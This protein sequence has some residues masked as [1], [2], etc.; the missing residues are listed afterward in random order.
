MIITNSILDEGSSTDESEIIVLRPSD[1]DDDDDSE[2]ED[3]GVLSMDGSAGEHSGELILDG[4]EDD[5]DDDDELETEGSQLSFP[6]TDSVPTVVGSIDGLTTEDINNTKEYFEKEDP[7]PSSIFSND[8]PAN[9]VTAAG[10]QTCPEP[11]NHSNK[12]NRLVLLLVVPAL[13]LVPTTLASLLCLYNER[14]TLQLSVLELEDVV[15]TLQLEAEQRRLEEDL[16]WQDKEFLQLSSQELQQK[17]VRLKRDADR[18]TKT[19]GGQLDRLHKERATLKLYVS[20]LQDKASGWQKKATLRSLEGDKL[21]QDRQFLEWSASTYQQQAKALQEEKAQ[22]TKQEHHRWEALQQEKFSLQGQVAKV[23]DELVRVQKQADKKLREEE[24][25]WNSLFQ[26]KISL[27][28]S[29]ARLEEQVSSLQIK[30]QQ[31]QHDAEKERDSLLSTVLRLQDQVAALQRGD[32]AE[33]FLNWNACGGTGETVLADNCWLNAKANIQLGGC[34]SDA[35][36]VVNSAIHDFS[37]SVSHWMESYSA[38]SQA[39]AASNTNKRALFMMTNNTTKESVAQ[40]VMRKVDYL[41]KRLWN[42]TTIQSSTGWNATNLNTKKR[43]G[44]ARDVIQMIRKVDSLGRA[45]WNATAFKMHKN[46]ND[47]ATSRTKNNRSFFSRMDLNGKVWFESF[48]A[49][50]PSR[51]VR[52]S[53]ANNKYQSSLDRI[54]QKVSNVILSAASA[55][56]V[57]EEASAIFFATNKNNSGGIF[58]SSTME[59]LCSAMAFNHTSKKYLMKVAKN[60]FE[61]VSLAHATATTM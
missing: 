39:Y 16:L 37:E 60:A 40:E 28:V 38:A 14:N 46:A 25:R 42:A 8:T 22:K 54:F 52:N 24:L 7:P 27:R 29:T 13:L 33:E 4:V 61:E 26:E 6:G 48:F 17:V 35:R 5:D 43:V 31:G 56:Q 32:K 45:L 53:R 15:S 34:A 3:W 12:T 19:C 20:H 23:Q 11:T 59:K 30:A 36:H 10:V 18:N 55:D 49:P 2:E 57:L 21:F 51:K 50:S 58:M 47:N 44:A 9:N 41:G 1:D